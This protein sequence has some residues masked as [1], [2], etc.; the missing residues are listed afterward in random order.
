MLVKCLV[1]AIDIELSYIVCMILFY[2][3]Y[4]VLLIQNLLGQTV[5]TS[6]TRLKVHEVGLQILF[7]MPPL[8]KTA[9]FET[10]SS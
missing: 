5:R 7:F 2:N 4:S 3:F 6:A 1:E 8:T 9:V 10:F